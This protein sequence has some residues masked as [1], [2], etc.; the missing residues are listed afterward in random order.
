MTRRIK[1]LVLLMLLLT[2]GSCSSYSA[3]GLVQSITNKGYNISF[4]SLNGKIIKKM[5]KTNVDTGINYDCHLEE[6]EVNIYY[7]SQLSNELT[8][9]C[10]ITAG[11]DLSG[12]TGY[13]SSGHNATIV[14][15]TLEKA[16]GSFSF[17]YS[18]QP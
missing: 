5:M 7:K 4:I 18:Y 14:I 12:S 17:S 8:L 3:I 13:I 6:G 16:K 15:E 11:E 10:H 9:I 2:L 1:F